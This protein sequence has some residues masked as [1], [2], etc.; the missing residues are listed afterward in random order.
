MQFILGTSCAIIQHS[1]NGNFAGDANGGASI[2]AGTMPWQ[3]DDANVISGTSGS[4]FKIGIS[5]S[6]C[7]SAD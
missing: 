5:S 3:T 1:S 4:Q 2:A 7:S 6:A